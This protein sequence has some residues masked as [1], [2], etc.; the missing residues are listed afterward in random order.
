MTTY[1]R[2]KLMTLVNNE[3]I[4]SPRPYAF[5][6]DEFVPQLLTNDEDQIYLYKYK[7]IQNQTMSVYAAL[8]FNHFSHT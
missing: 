4:P 3:R 6:I 5:L 8:T 2:D 7:E 1:E